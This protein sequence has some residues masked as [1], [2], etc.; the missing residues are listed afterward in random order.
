MIFLNVAM[1]QTTQKFLDNRVSV[2]LVIIYRF[3]K[4]D[5]FPLFSNVV[6]M[7]GNTMLLKFYAEGDK[8]R[9]ICDLH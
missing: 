2:E 1:G 8:M 6:A 5:Q 9:G 3:L 7:A 4:N